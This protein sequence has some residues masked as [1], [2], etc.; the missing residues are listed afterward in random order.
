[1]SEP[2]AGDPARRS[3]DDRIAAA[4]AVRLLAAGASLRDVCAAVVT[5]FEVALPGRCAVAVFDDAGVVIAASP[6]LGWFAGST[7]DRGSMPSLAGIDPAGCWGREVRLPD[8]P[9]VGQL[10]VWSSE[11]EP[12]PAGTAVLVE[13][14]GLVSL[15][16][17]RAR[18]AGTLSGPS[19]VDG[20][21]GL[22]SRVALVQR[23]REVTESTALDWAVLVVDLDRFAEVNQSHGHLLGDEALVE[24]GR[25]LGSVLR[26]DDCAARL[27]SDEFAVLACNLR[28]PADV[29]KVA[30]RLL[31]A[32]DLPVIA[33]GLFLSVTGSV[34]VAVSSPGGDPV[35]TLARAE[36]A[37]LDAKRAGRA[38]WR[39][40]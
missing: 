21:T 9:L 2:S 40:T 34:G 1:V 31:L 4:E 36:L 35:A 29:E 5:L 15:A 3:D 8:G 22:P 23:A 32:L 14:S 26:R 10:E 12:G 19:L 17:E 25:R 28:R 20:L 37:V 11:A 39:G 16:F 13:G 27:G 24:V 30:D 33:N 7:P 6:V 18:L 38:C